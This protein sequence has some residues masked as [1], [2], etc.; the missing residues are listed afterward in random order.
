[1]DAEFHP[2]QRLLIES[3]HEFDLHSPSMAYIDKTSSVEKLGPYSEWH[4]EDV[5]RWLTNA[6]QE[7]KLKKFSESLKNDILQNFK[8]EDILAPDSDSWAV[9]LNN[10]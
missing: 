10:C 7:G 1:M 3:E 2:K 9:I 4:N 5:C 8:N 6:M